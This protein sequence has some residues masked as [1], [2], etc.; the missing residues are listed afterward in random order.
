M[1]LNFVKKKLTEV[2]YR[3]HLHHLASLPDVWLVSKDLQDQLSIVCQD[4]DL[5]L[6]K[7]VSSLASLG[8]AAEKVVSS[9]GCTDST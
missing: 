8:Q 4:C 5:F 1:P 3:P 9:L 6:K 2:I 7:L